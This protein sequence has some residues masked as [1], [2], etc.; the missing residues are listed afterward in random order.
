[1]RREGSDGRPF[2]AGANPVDEGD[3]GGRQDEGPRGATT[4]GPEPPRPEL[5]RVLHDDGLA[6]V[7]APDRGG[8]DWDD[9]D[10]GDPLGPEADDAP[11]DADGWGHPDDAPDAGGEPGR[12]TKGPGVFVPRWALV[13]L[14]NPAD[15]LVLAQLIYWLAPGERGECRARRRDQGGRPWLA[16]THADLAAETGLNPRTVRGA[17]A[18]LR[19]RGLIEV[20]YARDRGLRMS[21]IRLRLD[22]VRR[23]A[24][25][26][27]EAAPHGGRARGPAEG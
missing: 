17:L 7:P 24:D 6:V 21:H 25:A 5:P 13:A 15:A 11:D 16:K 27:Q 18:R 10:P 20:R 26:P 22:A 14:G 9:P 8:D 23:L 4:R 1:M 3:G 19:A 12:F 2:R